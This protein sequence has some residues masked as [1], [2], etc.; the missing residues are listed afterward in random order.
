M[1][2]TPAILSVRD[3]LAVDDGYGW[4]LRQ[5]ADSV[6]G[7]DVLDALDGE[8]LPPERLDL[9]SIAPDERSHVGDLFAAIQR[10]DDSFSCLD[11]LDV[12]HLTI[13]A[14]LLRRILARA[15]AEL[16]RSTVPR[17]AAALVWLTLHGNGELH[18]RSVLTA[19]SIW[20]GFGV[21]NASELGRRLHR[22]AGLPAVATDPAVRHHAPVWIGAADLL[23]SR[24][25]RQL[26][27]RRDGSLH[28]I[29]DLRARAAA[30]APVR[31]VDGR[32]A[33]SAKPLQPRWTIRAPDDAGLHRIVVAFGYGEGG[34]LKV[35][36]VV[37]L[38]VP[39]AHLLVQQLQRALARTC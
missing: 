11:P 35:D 37:G 7:I 21:S 30:R 19:T 8:P 32:L 5:L 39:D 17:T 16:R 23:H 9:A 34:P 14:R 27:A 18:R 25:R 38:S 10:F 4:G 12:E 29:A 13:V 2:T 3:A 20:D 22:A 33:I 1:T 31:Q 36:E 26:I 24:T 15:P 28:A 6:G